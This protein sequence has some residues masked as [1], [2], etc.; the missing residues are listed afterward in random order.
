MIFKNFIYAVR[1]DLRRINELLNR[2]RPEKLIRLKLTLR[3]ASI[4]LSHRYLPVFLYRLSNLCFRCRLKVIALPIEYINFLLFGCEIPARLNIGTGFFL[5]HPNGVVIG[6]ARIEENV[7]IFQGVTLGAKAPDYK[8][9]PALRPVI[10]ANVTISPGA[11]ILG[12]VRI[13]I[14]ATIGANS[15]VTKDV[16]DGQ[17]WVGVPAKRLKH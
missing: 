8:Y 4:I 14:G 16:P 2:P 9:D 10:G 6:A 15:V 13:G 11:K 17:V 5:P 1:G 7:T 12:N 3:N